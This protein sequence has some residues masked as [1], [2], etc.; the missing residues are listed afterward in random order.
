[1][2]GPK[3]VAAPDMRFDKLGAAAIETGAVTC[4]LDPLGMALN[5]FP[6]AQLAY[7]L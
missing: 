6:I 4:E 2:L 3:A 1:M 7:Y 5:V